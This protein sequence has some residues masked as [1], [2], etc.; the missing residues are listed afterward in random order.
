M[1]LINFQWKNYRDSAGVETA[2]RLILLFTYNMFRFPKK[3]F[4]KNEFSN[5]FD[6]Y[7]SNFSKCISYKLLERSSLWENEIIEKALRNYYFSEG[8][9]LSNEEMQQ[10]QEFFKNEFLKEIKIQRKQFKTDRIA[11]INWGGVIFLTTFFVHVLIYVIMK[12]PAKTV[13]IFIGAFYFFAACLIFPALTDLIKTRKINR[14][15]KILKLFYEDLFFQK[16]NE[17]M[18]IMSS[19]FTEEAVNRQIAELERNSTFKQ[20][21]SAS[22]EFGELIKYCIRDDYLLFGKDEITFTK[23]FPKYCIV[24]L[25]QEEGFFTDYKEEGQRFNLGMKKE[26]DKLFNCDTAKAGRNNLTAAK[27]A[28]DPNVKDLGNKMR[29]AMAQIRKEMTVE[30]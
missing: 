15:G 23:N 28:W 22:A 24:D 12:N 25:L 13:W 6:V 21:K 29:K 17:E 7:K 16:L 20:L 3:D 9:S 26:L 27:N 14:L 19:Y 2:T 10:L 5:D 30:K 4:S 18:D 11:S 1:S 8:D